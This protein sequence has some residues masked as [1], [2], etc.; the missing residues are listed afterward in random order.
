MRNKK[1]RCWKII[2]MF[3]IFAILDFIL[4][5]LLKERSEKILVLVC[6][7]I[8]VAGIIMF[9]PLTLEVKD[10]RII[11]RIGIESLHKEYRGSFKKHVFMIDELRDIYVEKNKTV[12]MT[13]KGGKSATFSIMGFFNK[14]EIIN[15]IYEV[16]DQIKC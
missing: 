14:S 9:F 13:F 5:T 10:D 1:Y 15:L 8:L 4:I 3:V 11:T 16:Q 7:I 6:G 12:H 2:L